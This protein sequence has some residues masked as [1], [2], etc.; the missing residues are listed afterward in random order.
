MSW[1]CA[2]LSLPC[3]LV[4]LRSAAVFFYVV[5]RPMRFAMLELVKELR[6]LGFDQR[7]VPP[8]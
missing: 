2:L 5:T 1:L 4:V 8:L 7:F 3:D 6:R